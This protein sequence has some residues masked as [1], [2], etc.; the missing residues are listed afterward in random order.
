MQDGIIKDILEGTDGGLDIFK[1]LFPTVKDDSGKDVLIEKVADTNKAFSV[2]NESVPSARMR[3]VDGIYYLHDFGGANRHMNALDCLASEQGLELKEAIKKCLATYNI[4]TKEGCGEKAIRWEEPKPEDKPGDIEWST[5][6]FSQSDL[7]VMGRQVTAEHMHFYNWML[8]D[9]MRVCIERKKD[10]KLMVMVQRSEQGRPIFVRKCHFRNEDDKIDCFYKFYEPK[11][12]KEHRFRHWPEGKKPENYVHGLYEVEEYVKKTDEKLSVLYIMSGERDAMNMHSLAEFDES[13]NRFTNPN[14]C[15]WFNSETAH[16]DEKIIRKLKQLANKIVNVPDID[17]TGDA[18]G[19]RF[20][21]ENWDIY[22]LKLPRY[23]LSFTDW[24]GGKMKDFRDFVYVTM[25]AQ[26][27]VSKMVNNAHKMRFWYITTKKDKDGNEELKCVI[28]TMNVVFALNT[29]GYRYATKHDEEFFYIQKNHIIKRITIQDIQREFVG[30]LTEHNVEDIVIKSIIG[31]NQFS[32]WCRFLDSPNETIDVCEPDRQRFYLQD[33]WVEIMPERVIKKSYQD[34][35]CD[36]DAESKKDVKIGQ[37]KPIFKFQY[38][39]EKHDIDIELK[40]DN[41]KMMQYMAVTSCIYWNK[42]LETMR[43][44][45]EEI[46]QST[47]PIDLQYAELTD[48]ENF[49]QRLSFENKMFCIGYMLA[50]YKDAAK[51][52]AV[53]VMDNKVV[54]VNES[55]GGSGK[56]LLFKFVEVLLKKFN[57][58]GKNKKIG[59]DAHLYSGLDESYRFIL[60]DDLD[61]KFNVEMLFSDITNDLYVNP[62]GKSAYSISFKKSPKFAITTNFVPLNI[63]A[64]VKRRLRF[65]TVSDWFH[66][67]TSSNGYEEDYTPKQMFGQ[68]LIDDFNEKD[69]SETISCLIDCLRYYMICSQHNIIKDCILRNIEIR[70]LMVAVGQEFIE[71]FR[72]YFDPTEGH[73]N[74]EVSKHE[75]YLDYKAQCSNVVSKNIFSRKLKEYCRHMGYT[76]NPPEACNTND[77]RIIRREG[78]FT[79]EKFYISDK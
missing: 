20:A 40:N 19:V 76:Y 10:H 78:A 45:G 50:S 17:A 72:V 43:A 34:L 2:R 73:L 28:D 71:W 53:Y 68:T 42:V 41:C 56:S 8:V 9:E 18:Q 66:V 77:G 3:K 31:T 11:A 32:K 48:D 79:V 54:D 15:I 51:P 1:D 37:Y 12:A 23:L 63:D 16:V 46:S 39:A 62:K 67:R 24:R 13:S 57:I 65:A 4:Q 21:K 64:S 30:Y 29:L 74:M 52:W 7:K 27:E 26:Q 22:T 44:R 25:G 69:M 59:D 49:E 60:F 38:N 47:M 55:N 5:K 75:A 61:K 6:E 33:G 36:I 14:K 35:D 58:N 70:Q